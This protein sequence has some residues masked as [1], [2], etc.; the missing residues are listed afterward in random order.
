VRKT[1]SP[2]FVLFFLV[3]WGLPSTG[4]PVPVTIAVSMAYLVVVV[5][6]ILRMTG[7]GH[8]WS[9]MHQLGL[10]SGA[11][12]PFIVFAP[13]RE[14]SKTQPKNL[15]GIT[16]V[17]LLFA[18]LLGLIALRIRRRESLVMRAFCTNCAAA[19]M[20]EDIYCRECGGKL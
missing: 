12:S 5:W 3:F 13:V 6:I 20:P 19:V 4:L 9:S 8:L 11:V 17:A 18:V 7:N 14:L 1:L 2:A 10:V 15:A 16:L